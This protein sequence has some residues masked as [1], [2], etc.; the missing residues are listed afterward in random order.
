MLDGLFGQT[1]GGVPGAGASVQPGNV[2][3]LL[4][5]QACSQD[6]GE[7]MVVPVPGALVVEGNEEEVVAVEVLQRPGAVGAPGD[8]IS[9]GAGKPVQNGRVQ[10]EV[11]DGSRL[12]GEDLVGEVVDDGSVAAGEGVDEAGDGTSVVDAA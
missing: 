12:T 5:V 9:E 4:G 11:P 2:V 8:G 6:V 7:Q 1:V 3:G 10:Q